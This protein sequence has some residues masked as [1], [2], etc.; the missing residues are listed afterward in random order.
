MTEEIPY[1]GLRAYAL[2][3]AKHGTREEFG[4]SELDWIVSQSMKKKIFALLLHA[5]WIKKTSRT[6]YRCIAPDKAIKQ[7]LEFRVPQIIKQATKPYAF[8]RLSAVEIWSDYSYIQRGIERSPYFIKILKKDLKYWK[9]LFSTCHIPNY[10]GQGSTIGEF[11]ILIP[12]DRLIYDEK[13][14]FKVDPLKETMKQAK[15]NQMYIYPYK[16]MK[17]KYGDHT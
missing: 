11:V 10:V 1:Y 5:G 4:Q 12:V 2:F 7:L 6:R 15:S 9:E 17:R 3:F 16:Y 13:S 14:G 8:T